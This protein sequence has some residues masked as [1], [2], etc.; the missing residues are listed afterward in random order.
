MRIVRRPSLNLLDD[1]AVD[2]LNNVRCPAPARCCP[3]SGDPDRRPGGTAA[4][5]ALHAQAAS[6]RRGAGAAHGRASVLRSRPPALPSAP[7]GGAVPPAARAIP[8]LRGNLPNV[9]AQGALVMDLQDGEELF[10]RASPTPPA[11]SLPSRSWP[12]R[13]PSSSAAWR[14]TPLTTVGPGGPGRRPRRRPLAAGRGH[15]PQQ[16]G[17]AARR[18][19]GLGQP[20]GLGAGPGGR[21]VR[22]ASWRRP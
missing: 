2:T 3:R 9:Q 22:R 12:P 5:R 14:W 11:P 6:K 10:S 15:D 16:P 13:W 1:S 4:R 19:A 7:S 18:A 8:W 21:P 17:S 20:R